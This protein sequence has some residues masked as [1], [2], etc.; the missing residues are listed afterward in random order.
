[1]C[2]C[3]LKNQKFYEKLCLTNLLA[4]SRIKII[5]ERKEKERGREREKERV[6]RP[7]IGILYRAI[8]NRI[9]MIISRIFQLA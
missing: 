7:L 3:V 2:V 5:I 6:T 9:T 1:M 8:K 4:K